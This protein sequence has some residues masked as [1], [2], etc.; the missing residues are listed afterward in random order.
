M[1]Q[2][3]K[4][5]FPSPRWKQTL[6]ATW[7]AEL[8]ALTGFSTS[9]PIIPFFLEDLGVKDSGQLKFYTGM[10]QS[11]PAIAMAVMAPLWGALADRKGRKLMLLRAMFGGTILVALQGLSQ[12]PEQ[13]LVFKTLQGAVT[14]TIAAAMVL[15]ASISPEKERAY[16]LG[17]LQMAVFLGNSL[18]PLVGGYISDSFG[19]RINFFITA[20]LL[21]L[22]GCIVLWGTE[23]PFISPQKQQT[24]PKGKR[25]FSLRSLPAPTLFTIITLLAIVAIDQI[26]GS[27]TAPFLPL[28]IKALSPDA[29]RVASDTGLILGVGALTSSIAAV[30]IGK[31]S[32]QVGYQRLLLG[33]LLGA[34]CTTI[35]QA[36]VTNRGQ[37]L[38]LRALSNFF[39][40]GT[41]P[42]VNALLTLYS[43]PEKQGSLYGIRSSVASIG[44]AVGPLLGSAI[45]IGIGFR[46]VFVATGAILGGGALALRWYVRGAQERIRSSTEE[47]PEA[48]PKKG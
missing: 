24:A 45:A 27:I 23:D 12:T 22:G 28:F 8:L 11:L 41:M 6:Y 3:K 10:V 31:I 33:C 40:G 20:F 30:W 2:H 46:G 35:P 16:A 14:G 19:H 26:A 44:A 25:F 34:A 21:F 36:L 4:W 5:S 18:G 38:V 43:P 37:L 29:S 48:L 39:L 17:L 7:I 32:Y 47:K 15:V 13:L 9:S 42:T 1:Q